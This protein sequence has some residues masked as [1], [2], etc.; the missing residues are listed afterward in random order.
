[1]CNLGE[2]IP[3]QQSGIN[4]Y[5]VTKQC[6]VKPLCYNFSAPT[7]WLND[8]SN[9]KA[10]GAKKKAWTSCNREVEIKLVFG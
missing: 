4:L 6:A 2:L 3:I 5:D 9:I 10:I 7:S 8:P 1:M